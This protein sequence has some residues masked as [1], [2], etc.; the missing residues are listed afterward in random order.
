MLGISQERHHALSHVMQIR[1]AV[2]VHARQLLEVRARPL[3]VS[4]PGK[5]VRRPDSVTTEIHAALPW[6][7]GRLG[8]ER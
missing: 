1:L 8:I 7:N 6:V 3:D 5:N 4:L 2:I